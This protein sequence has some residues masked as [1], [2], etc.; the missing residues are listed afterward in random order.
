MEIN[1]PRVRGTL[2]ECLPDLPADRLELAVAAWSGAAR[3][4][5]RL[6][7]SDPPLDPGTVA[8]FIVTWNLRGLGVPEDQIAEAIV[9]AN[10]AFADR[11]AADVA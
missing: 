6:G 11:D 5:I 4:C 9:Y 3:Y 8:A 7:A 10:A 1:T 2:H